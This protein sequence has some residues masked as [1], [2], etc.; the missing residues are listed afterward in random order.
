[1]AAPAPEID[2]VLCRATMEHPRQTEGSIVAL[3]DGRLLL[4]WTDF[5]AGDWRD[6]GPAQIMARWSDDGGTSWSEPFLLQENIGRLN[7]MGASLLQLPSG[8]ILLAFMRKDGETDGED[9]RPVLHM[10]VKHSD[11]GGVTWSDPVQVTEGERYWCGCND[12]LVRLTNGRL[13]LPAE[14]HGIGCHAWLSDDDGATW[15]LSS[16]AVRPPE[17][18]RYAEPAVVELS[19]GT[20]AMFIRAT[21]GHIHIAHSDDGG[22]H[23]RLHS[24]SGPPAPFAPCIVRRVPGGSDLLLV[25][26]NHAIRSTLTAA[27][28]RDGGATW[29]NLRIIEEMRRWPLLDSHAYP[30]LTFLDD[31]AHITYWETHAHERA[32][33]LFHLVYRRLPLVWFYEERPHRTPARLA[34]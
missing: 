23:W 3:D 17:G 19:D 8:R 12:R 21:G 27:I 5:Y 1:M 26:N 6:R 25:W 29:G 18:E 31:S 10:M 28:S 22:E 15:R 33:R 9:E 2:T 11:D 7:V 20:V 34:R 13:L 30:T 14:E 24:D 4:A 32:G 16:G